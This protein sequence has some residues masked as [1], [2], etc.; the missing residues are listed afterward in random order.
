M[1]AKAQLAMT[2][3]LEHFTAVFANL[4][5]SD[6]RTHEGM[7]PNVRALWLWHAV[8]ETEHK[9]VAYDVYEQVC[10]SYWL[11]ALMMARILLGF[12]PAIFGFQ[13]AL[14]VGDRNFGGARDFLRG[15]RLVYG[16]GGFFHTALPEL[17]AFFRRD[18]HPWQQDNR[19]L[20]DEWA[21]RYEAAPRAG[22]EPAL[23]GR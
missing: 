13:L 4:L 16:P 2:I 21:Q 14:M 20:I 6:P 11:R 15:L 7:D 18:F 10:G 17:L 8:E 1:P 19:R 23:E 12:P 22:I 5:L 3:T 9:S